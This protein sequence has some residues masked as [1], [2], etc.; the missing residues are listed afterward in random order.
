MPSK[1][2]G[3]FCCACLDCRPLNGLEHLETGKEQCPAFSLSVVPS[4]FD[5]GFNY[6]HHPKIINSPTQC[7]LIQ[8]DGQNYAQTSTY[9]NWEEIMT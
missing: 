1:E 5:Y 7:H 8:A 3:L 9:F 4:M 6:L 2:K